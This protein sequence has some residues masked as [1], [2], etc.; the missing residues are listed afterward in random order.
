MYFNHIGIC[1][2]THAEISAQRG[3]IFPHGAGIISATSSDLLQPGNM[4]K[5]A[6]MDNLLVPLIVGFVL[7]LMIC[8][9]EPPQIIIA[10][11]DISRGDNTG[12]GSWMFLVAVLLVIFV[13][14]LSA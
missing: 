3:G 4:T 13:V 7:A 8:R 2:L 14:V 1:I 5:E 9:P 10:P 6:A 11:M 12:C